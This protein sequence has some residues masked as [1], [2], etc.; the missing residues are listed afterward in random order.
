MK[1]G[2]GNVPEGMAFLQLVWE[3]EDDCESKTDERIPTLGEKA[4]L[5]LERV[6]TVLSFLDR[7]ASC[8][9]EC[10]SNDH[11]VEYLCGRVGSAARAALRLLRFGFYD[12]SL[13]AC[14]IVGEVA[15]LLHLFCL[16]KNALDEWKTPPEEHQRKKGFAAVEVRKKLE[17]L[18][19]GP[20]IKEDRYQLLS[21]SVHVNPK[22]RPQAHNVLR[23]PMMGG[24][25]QEQ[26]LLLCLN[27]IAFP[28]S[29]AVYFGATLLDYE[30]DIKRPILSSAIELVEAIGKMEITEVGNYYRWVWSNR[31]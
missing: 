13:F 29:C 9:W 10:R 8:W 28:L 6:G 19:Q 26:G 14:R 1:A 18:Q 21:E 11:I 23:V 16:D 25:L 17:A 12:E 3:Q 4:P 31:Q 27:E 15:N 30:D 22:T 24:Q 7:M 5:C 2:H 20:V